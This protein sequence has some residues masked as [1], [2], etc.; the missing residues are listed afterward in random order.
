MNTLGAPGWTL[1][2][3]ARN[4]RAYGY[5][6]VDLRLIDGE[7]ITLAAVRANCERLQNLFPDDELPIAVLATSVRVASA[8]SASQQQQ[9][10]DEARAWIELAAEL[11]PHP[12]VPVVRV[13]GGKPGESF[14]P[15]RS[16]AIAAETLGSVAA[17]VEQAS[18]AVGLET[19]D[20]FLQRLEGRGG[21]RCD[22]QPRDRSDLGHVPHRAH[23]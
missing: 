15:E 5:A 9:V 4:A 18:V 16:I 19:H 2:E 17:D 3:V 11:Y 13:F 7:V 12:R 10:V 22:P 20:E 14:D 6:G 8:E 21:H 1:E 23:G